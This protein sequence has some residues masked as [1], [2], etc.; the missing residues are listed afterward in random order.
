MARF[1]VRFLG[2]KV[3]QADAL[4]IRD[5]LVDAGHVEAPHEQADVRVVNTC[6][7]TVEAE[8]K[9]RQQ[10]NRATRG[11]ALTFVT[12]CAANLN[13]GQFGDAD[14]VVPVPRSADRAA[15]EIV[16]RLGRVADPGCRDDVPRLPG[17]TR[18]FVKVQ[19]GCDARCAFCIIPTTR[20]PAESRPLASVLA[21]ARRRLD[22]GHPE[23]V[24]TGINIGTYRDDG[25]G[26][27]LPDVVRAVGRMEGLVRLRISSIEPGD[28]TDEL[29]AAMADTPTVGP[30]L[31]VPLQSGDPA[32][33]R[34]MRRS[35][36]VEEFLA[37]CARARAAL[38]R[39]NLT[40]DAIVGF[41]GEDE[42][43]FRATAAVVEEVGVTKVHVFPFSAR[44]GTAAEHIPGVVTPEERADRSARLR[45]LSDRLGAAHRRARVGSRDAV[46][47]EKA[48]ADGTLTGL[49][50][51]YTRFVVPAGAGAP[52]A[53]VAVEAEAVV[54]DHLL[55]R[56]LT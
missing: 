24:L 22:E 25:N 39:L 6:A 51:D 17:R 41:P 2:C 5:A 53:A 18:A 15:L 43:A 14:G 31:H 13:P 30:H 21:D 29:V 54:G 38:P 3:S 23:L 35:Y 45:D 28:V 20:G 16:E 46:I 10:V 56:P 19:N 47:L 9:S 34:A 33:L 40:T 11:G 36:R 1:S 52:G 26:A 8:R 49:G 37:G 7:L 50:A 42:A 4:L 44:P 55:G 48:A 12:G 27:L 32:V